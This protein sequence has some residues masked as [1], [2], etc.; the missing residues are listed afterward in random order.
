MVTDSITLQKTPAH[1]PALCLENLPLAA[2]RNLSMAV[3]IKNLH[4]QYLWAN[5]FFIHKSA[6]YQ[7]VNEIYNKQDH[8][9][10]WHNYA[11]KLKFNDQL[12]FETSE[13]LTLRERILRHEGSY[14]DIV[15]KKCPVVDKEQNIIG[16]IGFSIELPKS[17]AIET[18]SQR[19]YQAVLLMTE[20]YTDKQIAKKW[21]ISSRTVE[22]HIINA[23]RKLK[24]ATR[25]QLIA[26]FCLN[27]L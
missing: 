4:S 5:D 19:E 12:L 22:S 8:Y 7:S 2:Y 14:V 27:Q 10:S 3:F 20:G 9:F 17:P 6:G 24:V 11:D 23:K 25:S 26:K 15:S 16:L 18:L 21:S 13:E 1:K